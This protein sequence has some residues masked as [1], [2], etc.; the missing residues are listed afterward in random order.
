MHKKKLIH[1]N[2][3]PILYTLYDTYSL[4]TKKKTQHDHVYFKSTNLRL[5]GC[6]SLMFVSLK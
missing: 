4:R 5:N 1:T 2:K 3:P 6:Y